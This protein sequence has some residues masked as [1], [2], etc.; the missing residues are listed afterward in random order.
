[1]SNITVSLLYT[2]RDLRAV[3]ASEIKI[4][5]NKIK[6]AMVTSIKVKANVELVN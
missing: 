5:V 2:Y 4:V 6:I 3:D 1:M